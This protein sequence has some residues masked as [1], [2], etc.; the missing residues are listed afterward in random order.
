MTVATSAARTPA[1][2]NGATVSFPT[3]FE[4]LENST[5]VVTLVV[6]ATAVETVWTEGVQYT[7]TGGSG[8]NGTVTVDTSPTD[9]TPATGET[10]VIE[11]LEVDTQGTDLAR[12][13]R[14]PAGTIETMIDKVTYLIQQDKDTLSRAVLA[15]ITDTGGPYSIEAP[16]TSS[17]L[18]GNAAADGWEHALLASVTTDFDTTLTSELDKDMLVYDTGVWVN[19]TAAAVRASLDLEAGTDFVTFA[20]VIQTGFHTI[21]LPAGAMVSTTTNGAADGLSELATND[22]MLKTKDFDAST[23][24][25]A[26]FMVAMPVSWNEGIVRA[27]FVWTATA[28]TAGAAETVSWAIRGLSLSNDD[29]M[30]AAFGTAVVVADTWIA[31]G[32]LHI[33]SATGDVTL[34]GTPASGDLAVFDFYRD[35]SADDLVGDA[36]LVGV[37]LFYTVSGA[38]DN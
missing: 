13:G 16:V 38:N 34:S 10:L 25:H 22:V 14:L 26:Q 15:S 30:D 27:R 7:L 28:G 5:I 33:S 8:S 1:A 12:A 37:I 17:L 32:D 6:D 35:V 20:D 24:E 4:F 21:W 36:Q 2:G 3:V 29:A 31:D 11:R 23:D 9:Y 19:K 18:V